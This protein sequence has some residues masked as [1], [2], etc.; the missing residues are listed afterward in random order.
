MRSLP[1]VITIVLALFVSM[2]R[3]QSLSGQAPVRDGFFIGF[4]VGAGS[5][6]FEDDSERERGGTGYFKIGGALSDKI[7]LGA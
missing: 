1:L 7:L 2:S 6:G 5:L 3:A 4:G